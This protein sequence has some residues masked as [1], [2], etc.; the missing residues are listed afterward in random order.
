MT[1][2]PVPSTVVRESLAD[3]DLYTHCLRDEWLVQQY[4]ALRWPYLELYGPPAVA[5]LAAL[6]LSRTYRRLAD[7]ET[8]RASFRAQRVGLMLRTNLRTMHEAE[9]LRAGRRADLLGPS[10][11]RSMVHHVTISEVH[12]H[13][14]F[15]LNEQDDSPF[16]R[17]VRMLRGRR[18]GAKMR[19]AS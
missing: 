10:Q 13:G 19:R 3:V 1:A 9:N 14:G 18:I 15:I 4:L 11:G 17:A 16:L 2:L 12:P 5:T 8:A 6:D 7:M